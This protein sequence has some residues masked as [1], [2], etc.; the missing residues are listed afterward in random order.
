MWILRVRFQCHVR[1]LD[2]DYQGV[3]EDNSDMWYTVD[4]EGTNFKRFNR[5]SP[6]TLS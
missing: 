2:V 4:I 5:L 3:P 6:R 1:D